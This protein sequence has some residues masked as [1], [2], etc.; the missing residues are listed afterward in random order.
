[1]IVDGGIARLTRDGQ[2]VDRWSL[3]ANQCRYLSR[4]AMAAAMALDGVPEESEE[5]VSIEPYR[6]IWPR[7]MPIEF[8]I[9]MELLVDWDLALSARLF[10]VVLWMLIP[11]GRGVA[12][13][14]ETPATLANWMGYKTI[15]AVRRALAQLEARGWVSR[16]PYIRKRG[17]FGEPHGF[18]DY[19]LTVQ[20]H[21][22][23]QVA[24]VPLKVE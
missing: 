24:G 13:I 8:G 1:M 10:Y 4:Q 21:Q 9:P 2:R 6:S 14:R 3:S 22:E 15:E 16:V 11:W 19:V 17:Q 23:R 5:R 20:L 18:D 7:R 12:V